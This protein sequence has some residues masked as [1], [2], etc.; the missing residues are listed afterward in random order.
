ML[1]LHH[2][3]RRLLLVA[4]RL[5]ELEPLLDIALGRG[6]PQA[7]TQLQHLSILPSLPKKKDPRLPHGRRGPTLS[8]SSHRCV[9]GRGYD[10]LP[11]KGR[12]P[13]CRNG[14]R[15]QPNERGHRCCRGSHRPPET[16]AEAHEPEP[17]PSFAFRRPYSPISSASAVASVTRSVG[18]SLSASA[19]R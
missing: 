7:L 2:R 4:R 5:T 12:A 11:D 15:P 16:P 14:R 1:N 17:E 8:P 18:N 19:L 10:P 9:P 3:L 13:G 6:G